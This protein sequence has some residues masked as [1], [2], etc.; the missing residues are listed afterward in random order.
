MWPPQGRNCL[1]VEINDRGY[2]I[3]ADIVCGIRRFDETIQKSQQLIYAQQYSTVPII[4]LRMLPRES[5]SIRQDFPMLIT[6]EYPRGRIALAVDRVCHFAAGTPF[7]ALSADLRNQCKTDNVLILERMSEGILLLIN[8]LRFLPLCG[9]T[10]S[11]SP[12]S[13]ENDASSIYGCN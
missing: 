11:A 12:I 10:L 1:M 6:L 3:D 2:A 5:I 9:T 8:L 4:D 7:G 13:P